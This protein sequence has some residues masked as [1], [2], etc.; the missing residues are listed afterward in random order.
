MPRPSRVFSV[1]V[2]ACGRGG[3]RDARACVPVCAM[4][5]EG[6]R[7]CSGVAYV[8]L[9]RLPHAR[10]SR[11]AEPARVSHTVTRH[12]IVVAR[13]RDRRLVSLCVCEEICTESHPRRTKSDT[14]TLIDDTQAL[15]NFQS[16]NRKLAPRSDLGARSQKWPLRPPTEVRCLGVPPRRFQRLHT[17][18]R[19][20]PRR[21]KTQTAPLQPCTRRRA[22]RSDLR[23][24]SSLLTYIINTTSAQWGWG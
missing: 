18:P 5:E 8:E 14:H 17:H 16:P 12:R 1:H 22:P 11:A 6:G 19:Y 20:P 9:C 4:E 3:T 23:P 21:P 24:R 7:G 13:S 15:P 10:V 2:G